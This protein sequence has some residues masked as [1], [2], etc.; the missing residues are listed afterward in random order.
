MKTQ[1]IN[2]ELIKVLKLKEEELFKEIEQIQDLLKKYDNSNDQCKEDKQDKLPLKP[3]AK[4]QNILPKSKDIPYYT[5][6][7]KDPNFVKLGKVTNIEYVM[8]FI[9]RENRFLDSMQIAKMWAPHI[10]LNTLRKINSWTYECL[11]RECKLKKYFPNLVKMYDKGKKSIFWGLS[12][13]MDENGKIKSKYLPS[14]SNT[15]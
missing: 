1:E 5:N 10:P 9:I 13:W 7:P 2:N 4:P 8:F 3:E 6:E 14:K 12:E 15:K 11:S